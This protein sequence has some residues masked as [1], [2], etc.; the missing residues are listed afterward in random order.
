MRF[1][2]LDRNRGKGKIKIVLEDHKL[3]YEDHDR[4]IENADEVENALRMF[5]PNDFHKGMV[6]LAFCPMIM[7]S[8]GGSLEHDSSYYHKFANFTLTFPKPDENP[9]EK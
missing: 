6:A 7:E 3:H 2:Y 4:G 1:S 8:I 9:D 5:F